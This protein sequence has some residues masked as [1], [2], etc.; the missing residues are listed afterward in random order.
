[1][2]KESIMN[3]LDNALDNGRDEKTDD[4]IRNLMDFVVGW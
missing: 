4:V 1:M 3:M 2:D